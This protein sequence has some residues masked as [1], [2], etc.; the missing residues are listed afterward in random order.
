[1]KFLIVLLLQSCLTHAA[2]VRRRQRSE[3]TENVLCTPC[4]HGDRQGDSCL[5][6]CVCTANTK[7]SGDDCNTCLEG[8]VGNDCQYSDA[9]TC[10]NHG[11]VDTAGACACHHGWMTG[12]HCERCA[13]GF[14][15]DLCQFSNLETCHDHGVVDVH[16]NC[17]CGGNWGNADCSKCIGEE[18]KGSDCEFSDATTCHNHGIV[19]ESGVCTCQPHYGGGVEDDTN[20]DSFCQTCTPPWVG[21]KCQFSD[22]TNC[23]GHGSVD[24]L[25]VCHCNPQWTGNANCTKCTPGYAGVWNDC[26]FNDAKD[27][28]NHGTVDG[29]GKC[30]C[31]PD[32]KWVGENCN[33]CKAPWTGK[34]CEYSDEHDCSGHGKVCGAALLGCIDHDDFLGNTTSR[35]AGSCKCRNHWSGPSCNVCPATYNGNDCQYSDV[36]DCSNQGNVD[37]QGK[38]TCNNNWSGT[39]CQICPHGSAGADCQYSDLVDCHGHGIV[40]ASS[41]C[42]C[43]NDWVGKTCDVCLAGHNGT[44]CQFSNAIECRGNG[45]VNMDGTCDCYDNWKGSDVC[46]VCTR[47]GDHDAIGPQCQYTRKETCHNHGR[48]VAVFQLGFPSLCKCDDGYWGSN[49]RQTIREYQVNCVAIPSRDP[50]RC[51]GAQRWPQLA[52]EEEQRVSDMTKLVRKGFEETEGACDYVW[53]V[54]RSKAATMLSGVPKYSGERSDEG[55]IGKTEVGGGGSVGED[56]FNH[57]DVH[58]YK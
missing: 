50:Q 3:P 26:G 34:Q 15:G 19:S 48:P 54:W 56:T 47:T 18:F 30:T 13:L 2:S 51:C 20:K 25:G 58:Y 40:H 31:D 11:A 29:A 5:G 55:W 28:S 23:Y 57:Y 36:M 10:N 38:C 35:P 27:C 7:W 24:V 53:G 49:C 42:T 46:T 32:S 33:I 22:A 6:E 37:M 4:V 12:G 39:T 45:L 43:R 14:T 52:V 8:W 9:T 41:K 44:D 1:M 16:G 21:D 17:T